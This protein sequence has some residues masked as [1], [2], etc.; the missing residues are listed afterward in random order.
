MGYLNSHRVASLLM[1]FVEEVEMWEAPDYPQVSSVKLGW[2]RAKSYCHM[3]ALHCPNTE[4][5]GKTEISSDSSTSLHP[6]LDTVRLLLVP[7]IEGDVESL[8]GCQSSGSHAQMDIR[9]QPK[10]FF[11]RFYPTWHGCHKSL[12]DGRRQIVPDV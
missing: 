2:K 11:H 4:C 9:S 7:K 6:T 3:T 5:H 12:V 10:S 1:W 8:N